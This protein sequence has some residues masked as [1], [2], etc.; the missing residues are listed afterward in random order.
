LTP[1]QGDNQAPPGSVWRLRE[2]GAGLVYGSGVVDQNGRLVGLPDSFR[3]SYSYA[4]YMQI[5]IG[6][7][8]ENGS[9]KW[10]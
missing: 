2:T 3:S 5:E 8:Q 7:Y 6:C 10:P 1:F 9:I 4:G